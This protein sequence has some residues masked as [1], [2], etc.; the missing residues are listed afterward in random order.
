MSKMRLEEEKT[1]KPGQSEAALSQSQKEE[2]KF[3]ESGSFVEKGD[4]KVS[5]DIEISKIMNGDEHR[6]TIMIRNIPN[7]FK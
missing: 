6:T 3:S 5:N 1:D 7:K 4:E 2:A